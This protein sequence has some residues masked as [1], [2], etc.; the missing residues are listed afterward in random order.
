MACAVVVGVEAVKFVELLTVIL[1]ALLAFV[2]AKGIDGNAERIIGVYLLRLTRLLN[3]L[4]NVAQTTTRH[5]ALLNGMK[6]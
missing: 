2:G 1:I 6:S 5:S 3:H 4:A